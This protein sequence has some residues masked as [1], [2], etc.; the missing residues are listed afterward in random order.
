[1]EGYKVDEY[2]GFNYK[3]VELMFKHE[4]LDMLVKKPSTDDQIFVKYFLGKPLRK[5]MMNNMVEDL[6]DTP[7]AETGQPLL[8][9]SDTLVIILDEEPNETNIGHCN[10]LYNQ[11]GIFVA[12]FNIRRLQ[13][14]IRKHQLI[15]AVRILSAKEMEEHKDKYKIK[16]WSQFPDI[17]RFDPLA[18]AVFL[19]PGQILRIDRDSPV[20]MSNI[21]YRH[22]I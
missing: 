12:I 1:M 22:C 4:Q 5:E 19:R 6:F 21:Y 16:D 10:T 17:S 7:Q 15:P 11:S 18:L 14:N 9:K 3:E 13:F 2:Q 20:S 8:R